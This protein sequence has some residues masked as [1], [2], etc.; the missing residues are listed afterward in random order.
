M[1]RMP[2]LFKRPTPER[3]AKPRT[4]FYIVPEKKKQQI[5][6]YYILLTMA[7]AFA[8]NS[9]LE[10]LTGFPKLIAASGILLTDFMY[11]GNVGAAFFNSGLLMLVAF[12]IAMKNKIQLNGPIIAAI[13]TIGGFAFFGKDIYNIWPIMLGVYLYSK[14]IGESFK[15]VILLA[16]FG[17]ALGPMVSQVTFAYKIPILFSLPLGIAVGVTAGFLLPILSSSLVRFHQGYNLYNTGFTAG[18]VG[19]VFMGIFRGFGFQNNPTY[20]IL[21]EPAPGLM[22]FLLAL[23]FSM[24]AVGLYYTDRPT[25]KLMILWDQPGQLVS[26]FVSSDGF[27][28][29][30][31]N[32][33]VLGLL[34]V[35]YVM[36]IGAS[37]NGPVVGGIFTLAGFGAFGKHP[38]N[39]LPVMAGV[40]LANI[41][42][43]WRF[44]TTSA[45]VATLF[46][47]TL[48]PIAGAYGIIP[49]LIA[50]FLHMTVVMNVGYL[51]GGMNL[52]NNGFSGGFVAGILI[53]IFD[54]ISANISRRKERQ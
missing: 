20:M 11:T 31:L 33:G 22:I 29:V 18:F 12:L 15:T 40:I 39:A 47:T 49:G 28:V 43:L 51:H 36:V 44:Q 24:L 35:I 7:S 3:L 32:M 14:F 25:Q 52:Y 23:F 21:E 34:G 19:M 26:D 9:P 2:A 17:T 54:V 45:V 1:L 13:F 37:F 5:M 41:V 10:I 4:D 27:G 42:F 30:M 8:F 53:P 48:A 16:F 50:G 38:K 46:A 6:L